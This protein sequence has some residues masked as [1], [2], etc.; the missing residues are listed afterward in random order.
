MR[1]T[2]GIYLLNPSNDVLIGH[3]TNHSENLWSIPKGEKNEDESTDT[4]EDIYVIAKRELFEETGI[5]I[6]QHEYVYKKYLGTQQYKN[7]KKY[8]GAFVV[9]LKNNID[10][11]NIKCSSMV[12]LKNKSFPEIDKFEW[13]TFERALKV[14]HEAQCPFINIIANG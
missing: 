7:R 4:P 14:L 3:P 9:K 6:D 13:A 2:F 8:L 1:G 12:F 10:V 11:A 5:N